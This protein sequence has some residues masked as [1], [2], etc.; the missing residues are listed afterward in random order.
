MSC[1]DSFS[2]SIVF[3]P[4]V[5]KHSLHVKEV[6]ACAQGAVSDKVPVVSA[7]E[8]VTEREDHK[9]S[10]NS[11]HTRLSKADL[12]NFDDELRRAEC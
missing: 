9:K 11:S 2:A 6:F 3:C 1:D 4:S 12:D 7:S 8:K 10:N 5:D